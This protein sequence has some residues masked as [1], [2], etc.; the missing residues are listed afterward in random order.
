[1]TQRRRIHLIEVDDPW[2]PDADPPGTFYLHP[3]NH[4]PFAEATNLDNIGGTTFA[5]A[6]VH[7]DGEP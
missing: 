5:N 3:V 6:P 7:E 4:N 2:H 1:M